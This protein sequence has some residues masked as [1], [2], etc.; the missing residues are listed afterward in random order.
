MGSSED[1]LIGIP[2]PEHSS[3]LLSSLNEQRHRGVLC[4][5]T[6][7]TQGLEYRTHRAVLAACS[8]YFKKLFFSSS[9]ATTGVQRDV[10]E[11]DVLKPD[12]L[13]ALLEFA[14]T[15]T[16]TIS[17]SNMR[18]VLQAARLLEIPC[19]VDACLEILQCSGGGGGALDPA[20]AS[21]QGDYQKA[22]QYLDELATER[23]GDSP[24]REKGLTIP[25]P[26]E[27][28]TVIFPRHRK[29]KP[30]RFL[31]MKPTRPNNHILHSSMFLTRQLFASQP[32]ATEE[33]DCSPPQALRDP[34]PPNVPSS[35]NSQGYENP[36]L[37]PSSPPENGS[38]EDPMELDPLAYLQPLHDPEL[39]PSADISDNLGRKRRSQMPQECPVC[40]K[41]IHGAGKLPRHMRTHT[42]EKPFACQVC[43]VRFTRNDKLKI[44]MRKHTGE[45]PYSCQHCC[46]RFLHSYDLKNHMHLHTG[47]R[48]YEC[49]LCHKAFA[50]EDH[51]QRHMK[52]QNCLEVRTRRRR[53]DEPPEVRYHH[54]TTPA[55]GLDLSNGKMEDFRLS[56]LRYWGLPRPAV[57]ETS[58]EGVVAV[59]SL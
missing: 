33:N 36:Q 29:R 18:D 45:R 31:Q 28:P 5:I 56:M 21:H 53:K 22:K 51:L 40:H 42:G 48:P 26:E 11:L 24:S 49:S 19:V 39:T 55:E 47:D 35:D 13:G 1:E 37:A 20:D 52:G 8:H 4:D 6:I 23:A 58:P 10:C 54:P 59:E 41:I 44:H 14:Y 46:A 43:G 30:H 17:N 15:A 9:V 50:K 16:L 34:S 3:D 57:E 27:P 12:A 2:F 38:E 25:L 32:P 7:R